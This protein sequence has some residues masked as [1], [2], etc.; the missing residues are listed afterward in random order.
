MNKIFL[1]FQVLAR[2]MSIY[3]DTNIIHETIYWYTEGS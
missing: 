1:S 3:K 2:N